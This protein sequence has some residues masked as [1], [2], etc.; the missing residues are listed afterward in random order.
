MISKLQIHTINLL[1]KHPKKI[2]FLILII[3]FNPSGYLT[4]NEQ[5]YLEQSYNYFDN[6][7]SGYYSNYFDKNHTILLFAT[8]SNFLISNFGFYISNIILSLFLCYILSYS[9]LKLTSFLKFKP[10]NVLTT[11]LIF[12]LVDNHLL[13]IV[14]LLVVEPK[15]FAY[16]VVILSI[17]IISNQIIIGLFYI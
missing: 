5:A 4:G 8:I 2:L 14:G 17:V 1:N 16:G 12:I 7:V 15:A 11:I 10:L 6:G 9:I 13:H 3:I